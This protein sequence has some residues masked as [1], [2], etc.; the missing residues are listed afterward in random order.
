MSLPRRGAPR[1]P[2]GVADVKF[3]LDG[4]SV[5][6]AIDMM[7]RVRESVDKQ[8][9]QTLST[10]FTIDRPILDDREE[11]IA[12]RGKPVHVNDP[13]QVARLSIYITE[14]GGWNRVTLDSVRSNPLDPDRDQTRARRAVGLG[15]RGA[16]EGA[17]DVRLRRH[18]TRTCRDCR[19]RRSRWRRNRL[20]DPSRAPSAAEPG[21][22]D[23]EHM[24]DVIRA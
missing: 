6:Q 15:A 21:D 4:L 19:A 17:R 11:T 22:I 14:R 18:V 8:A 13:L 24:R 10:H 7:T 3:N 5:L 12:G 1:S 9:D 23:C 20:M 16:C 2:T